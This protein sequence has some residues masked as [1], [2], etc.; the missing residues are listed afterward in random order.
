MNTTAAAHIALPT[1]TVVSK[2]TEPNEA[3]SCLSR[4][5]S[6]ERVIDVYRDWTL[7]WEKNVTLEKVEKTVSDPTFQGYTRLIVAI[8]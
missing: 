2:E 6:G 4:I 5:A 1:F 7:S 3:L 8:S